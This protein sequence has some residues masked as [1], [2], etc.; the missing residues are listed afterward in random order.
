[1]SDL[2][3]PPPLS[4]GLPPPP[5]STGLPPPMTTGLPPPPSGGG[6]PPPPL[7]TG[8]PPP[9]LS[10]G[11][12]PPPSGG[13]LPPPPLSTGLPPPPSG[14]GLPP[15][16]MST[17][18]P[19]PP[20]STG[21]PSPPSGSGLPPPPMST[22]LPPPPMST[23]L[24]PPPSGGGLP[25]PPMS[26]GLPPPPPSGS[27]L[28]P[29]PSSNAVEEGD[30]VNLSNRDQSGPEPSLLRTCVAC[31]E[32]ITDTY[33]ITCGDY[34][35]FNCLKCTHCKAPIKPPN[36]VAFRGEIYCTRCSTYT[37]E[38]KKCKVCN[39]YLYDVEE[40]IKPPGFDD[41][42]H[43]TCFAC[44]ECA[45]ELEQ[46]SFEMVCG[47][48]VCPNCV[49]IVKKRVCYQCG[50]PVVG[51]YVKNRGRYFHVEHFVCCQC[52]QVLYGRNF[53]V[54]HDQYYCPKDGQQYLRRCS[55]CK[56]DFEVTETE[57]TKWHK[58]I[59]HPNCFVCR[60]CGN[61]CDPDNAVDIHGRPHCDE[62][63]RKRKQEEQTYQHKHSPAE[64]RERRKKFK[65]SSKKEFYEPVYAN[66]EDEHS[67]SEHKTKGKVKELVVLDNRSSSAEVS[68]DDGVNFRENNNSDSGYESNRSISNQSIGNSD[69]NNSDSDSNH[70][71]VNNSDSGSKSDSNSDSGSK[72]DSNSDSGSKSDS[73]SDSGSNSGSRSSG[74]DSN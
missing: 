66:E 5:L 23:G 22:G 27:G 48:P 58:K 41:Y 60:V 47:F 54:H 6:L 11:L 42:I 1:M 70:G 62:C 32:R 72:S 17:G 69:N 71:S 28:P 2:P 3:P 14:G 63:A 74:D 16:P 9:P 57:F 31:Q 39:Q 73:N 18:L 21:L 29:P 26:T 43:A 38:L 59:Y 24:P 67:E 35:H 44:Y 53:I 36:C 4:T 55:Y 33:Y 25:P 40:R 56:N 65:S 20:L 52:E 51:R 61:K 7:S 19:P 15:P 8:L 30:V 37:G 12:P 13:G 68:E 34:Y 49:P 10:T 45:A 64:S 46:E 50:E